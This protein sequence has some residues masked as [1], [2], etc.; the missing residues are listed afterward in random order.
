MQAVVRRLTHF[1]AAERWDFGFH[2]PAYTALVQSLDSRYPTVRFGDI[3]TLMTDMGAFS[4]Y[5]TEYFVD[6]GIPFLRVQ[7]V[8]EYGVDLIRD[9]KYISREYHEQLEKSQLQPDDLLLTTKAVIGV[10][11]VVDIIRGLGRLDC[12]H[13]VRVDRA[14]GAVRSFVARASSP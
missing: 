8:Q 4:L 13:A 7:N 14:G 11:A 5:K 10:A 12:A 9:T 6:K 1:K 2:D 3:I